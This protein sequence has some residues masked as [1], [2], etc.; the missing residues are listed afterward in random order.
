MVELRLDV[1]CLNSS[2]HV[3]QLTPTADLNPTDNAS[4]LETIDKCGGG[5]SCITP[6]IS[7]DTDDAPN[8]SSSKRLRHRAL[9]SDLHDVL[10]T[11]STCQLFRRLAPCRISLVVDD[12]VG[13]EM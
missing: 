4:L 5:C 6:D 12:K 11:H 2:H 3:F 13:P 7:D 1:I 10:Y 8:R 9:A